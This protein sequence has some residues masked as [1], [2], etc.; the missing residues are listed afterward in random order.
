M[1]VWQAA[2]RRAFDRASSDARL[3][4]LASFNEP[5]IPRILSPLQ[6]TALRSRRPRTQTRARILM[7]ACLPRFASTRSIVHFT[8]TYFLF[9]VNLDS[10]VPWIVDL[11]LLLILILIKLIF[12]SMA[13]LNIYSHPQIMYTQNA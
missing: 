7:Q 13:S 11:F 9:N 3:S 12:C 5:G 10:Y 6:P 2:C 1:R 8:E 4:C